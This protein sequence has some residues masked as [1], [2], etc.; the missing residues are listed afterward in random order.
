MVYLITAILIFGFLVATHELGHFLAAKA[1]GVRVEEYA[2]GM[3]PALFKRTWGETQYSLRLLPVGGFC[4]MT[5]ED[6]E[7]DDPR[8]LTRQVWWK[9]LIIFVAGA[10]MNLL[11]GFLIVLCLYAGAG[12]FYVDTVAGL[13]PETQVQY[14]LREGDHVYRVNGFRTYLSGDASTFLHYGGDTA[15]L[16]VERDGARHTVTLVRQDCTDSEGETYRGYGIYIGRDVV[17]AERFSTRLRYS[18]YQTLDYVQVVWFSLQML[19]TGQ[20]GADEL[21]G[22][23]GIVSSIKEIG[24]QTE[25]TDGFAAAMRTVFY[26]AALIAV[27]LCVMNL[28]PL[29]ALDG[30][31]VLF[32]LLNTALY[33]LFKKQIPAKYQAYV[34]A[35]GLVL[36][37]GLML[38]VTF[39]D[40]MKLV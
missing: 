1:C 4:A 40:V 22:P 34:D 30:G 20:A 3:G 31:K 11:T 39:N 5:G 19:V 24:E 29:P 13:A 36:L 38:F 33:A 14:D 25:Q 7:S 35:A 27:N 28:L 15:Q 23:V 2:I 26:F 6:E 17:L 8:A 37:L 18:W 9:Q 10:A 16:E 32:L 12:G 21:N